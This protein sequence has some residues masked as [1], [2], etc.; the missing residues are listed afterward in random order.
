[1]EYTA[2]TS[3]LHPQHI[4]ELHDARA[5]TNDDWKDP[6]ASMSAAAAGPSGTQQSMDM[7]EFVLESLP[8]EQLPR[9]SAKVAQTHFPHVASASSSSAPIPSSAPSYFNFPPHTNYFLSGDPVSAYNPAPQYRS[10]SSTPSS[11]PLSNYSSLNGATSVSQNGSSQSHQSLSSPP[12]MMIES[13]FFHPS[14]AL[15]GTDGGFA[16][17]QLTVNS[18]PGNGQQHY[19]VSYI[20][21]QPL[22]PQRAH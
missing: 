22:Q 12:Q 10:W 18:P 3:W 7:S 8:G 21:P 14:G 1:M 20:P 16:S 5:T 17:P 15:P 13:V 11:I 6:S 4:S 19:S 9:P 2:G